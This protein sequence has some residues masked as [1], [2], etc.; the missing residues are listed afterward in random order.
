MNIDICDFTQL[1]QCLTEEGI[2]GALAWLNER[3]EHRFTAL[4][5]KDAETLKNIYI[6]DRNDPTAKPFIDVPM[7]PQQS[8]LIF[9]DQP[10]DASGSAEFNAYCGM[11]LRR[12]DGSIFGAICHFDYLPREIAAEELQVLSSASEVLS[13]AL[14][15]IAEL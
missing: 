15:N 4:C 8:S 1:Q 10:T 6:F 13:A 14:T 3:V 11:P 9:N 2:R 12:A 5:I 7:D